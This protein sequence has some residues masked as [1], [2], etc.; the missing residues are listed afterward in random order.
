MADEQS[1]TEAQA[2]AE[3][4]P[5]QAQFAI[6]HVYLKDM[7]LETPMGYEAFTKEI[8]QKVD[9]DLNTQSKPI[10]DNWY[11]VVLRI[12]VTVKDGDSDDT[13]YLI[14]VH[15]AGL[16]FAA[17]LAEDKTILQRLEP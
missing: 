3:Q 2:G 8:K 14:E 16:F 10:R 12:T 7:S 6:D 17:G 5:T 11:E 1:T 13:L 9:L 4:Q 15:Q